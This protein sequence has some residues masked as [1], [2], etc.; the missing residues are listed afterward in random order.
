MDTI[1][2]ELIAKL[3]E[4]GYVDE[5]TLTRIINRSNRGKPMDNR[6]SKRKLV[7][8]FSELLEDNP[9][10]LEEFGMDD[11]IYPAL[12]SL[13]KIKPQRTASG[14]ATITVL[15]KPWKCSSDC[16]YCPN[17]VRMPKSYLHKE[18]G[19]QRAEL[20]YFDPYLQ[21]ATRLKAL[22]E[23]GHVI[24]K[25]EL[26]VLGGTW[27]DYP[28]SYQI[29]FIKELFR[30][31][32]DAH[33]TGV[34]EAHARRA[35]YSE[36]GLSTDDAVLAMQTAQAQERV[37]S[38]EIS[39][40]EAISELYLQNPLWQKVAKK[41][42]ASFEELEHEQKINETAKHRMVGLVIET[43]PETLNF[44]SLTTIRRLGCTKVQIGIQSVDSEILEANH[45]AVSINKI[46]RAFGLLRIFGFKVH[47]HFMLNLYGS[48]PQKDVEDYL[49]FVTNPY[50]KPDEVKIYPCSLVP[51]THL[52]KKYDEKSWKPYS[53]DELVD[54]LS[55]DVLNTEVY[56]R[57]SRMIRDIS[58]DDILVGNKQSNLR[59]DVEAH[60]KELG[61]P[62]KEIRFRE[63]KK[64][65]VSFDELHMNIHPYTTAY[66]QEYFLE[67]VTK[68]NLIAG[69]LR[70]SLPHQ[71]LI[72]EHLDEL[73]IGLN[74]A[75]I[76]EVH[77]YGKVEGLDTEGNNAQHIGLGKCLIAKA[78]EIAHER[79]FE[80]INV[81][82]SIGTRE[83]YK[84]QGFEQTG[85]YQQAPLD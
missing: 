28:E 48:N 32:N 5:R 2:Q 25:I 4:N 19:A 9:D 31:L 36:L 53:Y 16:L 45:R 57:I 13:L 49:E 30:A 37:S 26:I 66:S 14:V 20:N 8:Y 58:K 40:N 71:D 47:T 51:D 80:K 24:D 43:R 22:R 55:I 41:Q 23:M 67:W 6:N 34:T 81:I 78:K 61:R 12:S 27:T 63:I 77:V 29:W 42:V 73:P 10:K 59:E 52:V 33:A 60:V 17:D 83:Y 82:S 3:K 79:G 38:G 56:T 15:T 74:E 39:F 44:S 70:L 72:S 50:Y 7:V 46:K 18:P 85:L 75:M 68:E 1:L 21:V 64:R 35:F 11:E 76:R 69:F 65:Q 54:A 84:K 62:V